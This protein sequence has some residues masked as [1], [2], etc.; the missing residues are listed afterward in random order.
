[1]IRTEMIFIHFS[2]NF[3]LEKPQHFARFMYLYI[4]HALHKKLVA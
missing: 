2:E 1:M 3:K 4:S